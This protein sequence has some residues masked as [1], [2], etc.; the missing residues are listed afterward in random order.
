[1]CGGSAD[2]PPHPSPTPCSKRLVLSLSRTRLGGGVAGGLPCGGGGAVLQGIFGLGN[3]T[4]RLLVFLKCGYYFSLSAIYSDCVFK[5][6]RQV[7]DLVQHA[8]LQVEMILF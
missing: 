3:G 8:F 2:S 1:V 7:Q 5:H 6:T 4:F